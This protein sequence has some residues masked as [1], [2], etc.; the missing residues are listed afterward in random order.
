MP[1]GGDRFY[2]F[3]GVPTPIGSHTPPE[4][5][6]EEL[7]QHFADWPEP[8]QALIRTLDPL[9]SNRLEISDIDPPERLAKGRIAILGDAA[10][11]TT[12]TLGQ[13]GC[14]AMEDA[15]RHG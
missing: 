3:F 11:A 14:Q 5:R 9:D 12:P 6:R 10:H 4:D 15:Y 7:A 1:V 2:Y 8:V 13:G